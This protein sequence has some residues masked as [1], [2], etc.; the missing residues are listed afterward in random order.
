MGTYDTETMTLVEIVDE[1]QKLVTSCRNIAG[2]NPTPNRMSDIQSKTE[3]V[4]TLMG[5]LEM[6]EG[7]YTYVDDIFVYHSDEYN[8]SPALLLIKREGEE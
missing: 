5:S 3:K 1:I 8:E 2:R 7:S 4:L 6:V